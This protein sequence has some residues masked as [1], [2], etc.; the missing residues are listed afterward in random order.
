MPQNDVLLI[1]DIS[2]TGLRLCSHEY[3]HSNQPLKL[4]INLPDNLPPIPVLGKVVWI[5]EIPDR[6]GIPY[7]LGLEFLDIGLENRQRIIR[8]MDSAEETTH[9]R[10]SADEKVYHSVLESDSD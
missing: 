10:L 8:W 7:D 3:I 5:K 2:A 4:F 6:Q 9:L 1:Q